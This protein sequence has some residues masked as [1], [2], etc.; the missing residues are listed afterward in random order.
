MGVALA[1]DLRE[2]GRDNQENARRSNPISG[3]SA[4]NVMRDRVPRRND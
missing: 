2:A 4:F 1:D 3:D